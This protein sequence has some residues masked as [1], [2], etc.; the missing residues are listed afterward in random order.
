[1]AISVEEL[2]KQLDAL[3]VRV[4]AA[5]EE[6]KRIRERAEAAG[7]TAART[8]ERVERLGVQGVC[9]GSGG[10]SSFDSG[11]FGYSSRTPPK[12]SNDP[13]TSSAGFGKCS[14]WGAAKVWSIQSQP[15]IPP[16][17]S[18]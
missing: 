12:S 14:F 15:Q 10:N 13:E 5:E 7:T 18:T 3:Q 6:N 1:M 11:R 16:A 8:A 17:L 4:M 2:G 9:G